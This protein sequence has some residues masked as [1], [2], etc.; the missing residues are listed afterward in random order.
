MFAFQCIYR[1]FANN[2]SCF[3]KTHTNA[4]KYLLH[5]VAI[6]I[7]LNGYRDGKKYIQ[8]RGNINTA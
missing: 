2:I 6:R 8:I 7:Q 1:E 5:N 4:S 3:A